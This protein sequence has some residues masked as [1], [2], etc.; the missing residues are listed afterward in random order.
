MDNKEKN[1][2]THLSKY[3]LLEST[4]LVNCLAAMKPFYFH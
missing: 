3:L 4:F 1:L 2:V